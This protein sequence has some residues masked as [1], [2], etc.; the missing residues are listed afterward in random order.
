[1]GHQV[2]TAPAPGQSFNGWIVDALDGTA[3]RARVHCAVCKLTRLASVELLLDASLKPCDC[4]RR[5]SSR[6][7]AMTEFAT[8]IAGL[9]AH[10]NGATRRRS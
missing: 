3:K 6:A 1:M 4:S 9:E 7:A 2:M 5:P 10:T 8:E